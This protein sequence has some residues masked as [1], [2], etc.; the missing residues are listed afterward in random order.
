SCLVFKHRLHNCQTKVHILTE[1]ARRRQ[2]EARGQHSI[3]PRSNSFT[4]EDNLG[5]FT[6]E[7]V[8]AEI[9]QIAHDIQELNGFW[10]NVIGVQYFG[11]MGDVSIYGFAVLYTEINL[12]A[13]CDFSLGIFISVTGLA[14]IIYSG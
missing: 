9:F 3:E 12:L 4:V 10:R 5:T 13:K 14:F 6:L 1:E 8:T 11:L 7:S 2:S